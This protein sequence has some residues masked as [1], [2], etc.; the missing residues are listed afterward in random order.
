MTDY[1][2][3]LIIGGVSVLVLVGVLVGM[4]IAQ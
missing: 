2:L 3:G 4:W 1:D